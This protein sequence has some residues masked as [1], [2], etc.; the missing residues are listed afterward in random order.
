MLPRD[1][2]LQGSV[3]NHLRADCSGSQL[4]LYVNGIGVAE[5]QASEW[6]RGD[7]GLLTGTG[8]QPGVVID[9]DNFSVLQP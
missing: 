2:V 9:F 4:R 3:A 5:A 1:A 8:V 7:V 6:A